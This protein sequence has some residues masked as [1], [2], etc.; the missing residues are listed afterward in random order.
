MGVPAPQF[1]PTLF[2]LGN[3]LLTT[4]DAIQVHGAKTSGEVEYVLLKHNDELFVTV[5][6]GPYGSEARSAFHSESQEH[7]SKCNGAGRVAL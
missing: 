1:I 2:A 5:G 3:H 7:V 6:I 4:S